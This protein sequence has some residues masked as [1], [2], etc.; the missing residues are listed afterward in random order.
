MVQ[1]WVT[2]CICSE[3]FS[4]Q[5]HSCHGQWCGTAGLNQVPVCEHDEY[6]KI[7]L[8]GENLGLPARQGLQSTSG[9]II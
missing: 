3:S 1:T 5:D 2:S 4:G 6:K 7:H 9:E 8:E